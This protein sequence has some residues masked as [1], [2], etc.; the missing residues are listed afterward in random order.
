MKIILD[1]NILLISMPKASK[2]RIIFDQFLQQ[3]FTLILSNDIITEYYEVVTRYTNEKI[4]NNL[5]ELLLIQPNA[6]KY[7][8]FYKWCLITE[9]YDDNKFV[10]L[11]V[12]SNADYIV[13]NDKHFNIL[14]TIEFPK[15]KVLNID[16]FIKIINS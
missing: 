11:A 14:K 15:I 8:I 9:D 2:Y 16:E 10:D 12:V 6:E 13:T 3:K 5:L 7:E 1:S 4:A